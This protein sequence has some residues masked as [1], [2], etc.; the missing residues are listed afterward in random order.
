LHHKKSS[1]IEMAK[2]FE[3]PPPPCGTLTYP[4]FF[5]LLSEEGAW[6]DPAATSSASPGTAPFHSADI[7]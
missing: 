6:I 2:P 1:Y 4:P 5:S 3:A 7:E